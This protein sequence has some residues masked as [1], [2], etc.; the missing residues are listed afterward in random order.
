M[1]TPD[2]SSLSTLT[3]DVKRDLVGLSA[4]LR[5][6][7]YKDSAV[8]TLYTSVIKLGGMIQ[9]ELSHDPYYTNR[10]AVRG[11]L[12]SL[13]SVEGSIQLLITASNEYVSSR[14]LAEKHEIQDTWI[15]R[16]NRLLDQADLC[17]ESLDVVLAFADD[18]GSQAS[19]GEPGEGTKAG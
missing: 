9:K 12:S 15:N 10:N 11:A 18:L 17:A 13:R 8:K 4:N 6:S 14:D 5:K 2:S 16:K 1:G 19:T 7:L 3:E